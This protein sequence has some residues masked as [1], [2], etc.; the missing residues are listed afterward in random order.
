MSREGGVSTK[1]VPVPRCPGAS[2]CGL[3]GLQDNPFNRQPYALPPIPDL[4][5]TPHSPSTDPWLAGLY[6][7]SLSPAPSHPAPEPG[8]AHCVLLR[9]CHMLCW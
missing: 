6:P 9:G 4:S 2:C 3:L 7:K 8:P 5:K 1:H